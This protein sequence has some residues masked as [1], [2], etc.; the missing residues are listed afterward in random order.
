MNVLQQQQQQQQQES[1]S[2]S[3]SWAAAKIVFL[4]QSTAV[5]ISFSCLPFPINSGI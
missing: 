5:N 1:E 2:T 4:E 3:L